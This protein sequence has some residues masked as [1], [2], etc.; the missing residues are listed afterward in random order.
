MRKIQFEKAKTS[1]YEEVTKDG[2]K[3]IVAPIEGA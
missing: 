1:L 3:V 2:L